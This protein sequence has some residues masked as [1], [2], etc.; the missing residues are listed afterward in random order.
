[1]TTRDAVE[2][3]LD[4]LFDR[5]AGTGRVGRR[6]LAEAEDHLAT[7]RDELVAAGVPTE[8]AAR[9]AVTR[10]GDADRVASDLRAAARDFGG[11][12]RQLVTSGWLLGAIGLVAIGLSGLLAGLMDLVGGAQFVAGDTDGITYT[13]SRCRDFIG[14]FPGHTCN[15][16]AALHHTTEVIVYRG[17]VGVLGL[18]ALAAYAVVRR[19]PLAGARW[20]PRPDLT[21][22]VATALFGLAAVVLGGPALLQ[23]VIGDDAGTGAYLSAGIVAG[24]VALAS[25]AYGVR[26]RAAR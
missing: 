21:A 13:A 9:R 1:M 26:L 22:L 10:F 25:A 16:A 23:A 19:G 11:L 6:A 18:V 14:Y 24:L 4:R 3:Y 20:A 2:E 17:A 7:S 5:L 8:E 15:A 12:V